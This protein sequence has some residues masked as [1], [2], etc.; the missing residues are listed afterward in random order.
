M[1][2]KWLFAF[3]MAA[4]PLAQAFSVSDFLQLQSNT[5]NCGTVLNNPICETVYKVLN[6][7]GIALAINSKQLF[8]VTFRDSKDLNLKESISKIQAPTFELDL[9]GGYQ[10]LDLNA[11]SLPPL[12][13]ALLRIRAKKLWE[14]VPNSTEW[15]LP[16]VDNVVC[17]AGFCDMANA[18]WNNSYSYKKNFTVLMP[19]RILSNLSFMFTTNLTIEAEGGK[20]DLNGSCFR[21]VDD[22]ETGELVFE[23]EQS[24]LS[25]TNYTAFLFYNFTTSNIN[26][27]FWGYYGNLTSCSEGN[28][29]INNA[30]NQTGAM[31]VSHLGFNKING[32]SFYDSAGGDQNFSIVGSLPLVKTPFGMG[33]QKIGTQNNYAVG[34]GKKFNNLAQGSV[35]MWYN[36]SSLAV[37]NPYIITRGN[38]T[39]G[40]P[41]IDLAIDISSSRPSCSLDGTGTRAWD[42]AAISLNT[43]YLIVCTWNTTGVYNFRNGAFAASS[44]FTTGL[45]NSAP[46]SQL[47]LGEDIDLTTNIFNGSITGVMFFNRSLSEQEIAEL[48]NSSLLTNGTEQSNI[49]SP[50]QLTVQA[51]DELTGNQI[52]FN[53]SFTNGTASYSTPNSL[54]YLANTSVFPQNSNT[55]IFQNASYYSRTIAATINNNTNNVTAYM[56]P[57]SYASA[58]FVRISI[59]SITGSPISGALVSFSRSVGGVITTTASCITDSSGVCAEYLDSLANYQITASASGY[60]TNTVSITPVGSD[61]TITLSSSNTII[62]PSS[63]ANLTYSLL[64]YELDLLQ[65]W[66]IINWTIISRDSALSS[67][68]LNIS[69]GGTIIFN[70]SNSTSAGGTILV[71]VSTFGR[72]GNLTASGFFQKGGQGILYYSQTYFIYDNVTNSPGSLENIM[73]NVNRQGTSPFIIGALIIIIVAIIAGGLNAFL[74]VGAGMGLITV[75]LLLFFSGFLLPI[76]VDKSEWGFFGVLIIL[77]AAMLKLRSGQ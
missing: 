37:I 12:G 26:Y 3:L 64:P 58:V 50:S 70:S 52:Y 47:T 43:W 51:F 22:N 61:Y 77:G 56:I 63:Y 76:G 15:I 35:V 7:S 40:G 10:P 72:V 19:N 44:A 57:L 66:T 68:G 38:F 34:S 32:S 74:T 11:F 71:N 8:N 25:I 49:T 6:P 4:L 69:Y 59:I 2:A 21:L 48:Y 20:L 39:A 29:N 41:G 17:V 73:A 27:T 16:N 54:T 30:W 14:Q 67:W 62:Y 33:F 18:W 5:P 36:V 31:I 13:T 1:K 28:G 23:H 42:A 46:K 24:N 65:N 60:A 53:A 45:P 9:G 55:I 75:F